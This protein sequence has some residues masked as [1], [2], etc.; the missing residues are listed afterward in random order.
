MLT[1]KE[2]LFNTLVSYIKDGVDLQSIALSKIAQDAEIGKSTV[3]EYFE[4]KEQMII[5]TYRFLLK[6]Y[7]SIL[8]QDI[9]AMDFKGAL[10]EELSHTLIVLK[11]ARSL[12]EAIMKVPYH[13][14]RIDQALKDEINA[15][16][17]AME[18]RF[19]NIMYLG[20]VEGIFPYQRSKKETPYVIRALISG[21]MFQFIN[22]EMEMNEQEL[23]ELIYKEIVRVIKD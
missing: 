19:A 6:H 10:F 15:I 14:L 13:E 9:Q 3:Y 22:G 8:L 5:E 17:K 21:L 11:D 16:Q 1:A 2:K 18:Q 7:E 12:M 23:L 4:S 20:A